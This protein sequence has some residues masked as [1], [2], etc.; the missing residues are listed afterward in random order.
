MFKFTF[1][2]ALHLHKY[3]G[4]MSSDHTL[5]NP[6]IFIFLYH[7][8]FCIIHYGYAIIYLTFALDSSKL[9]I[10]T[11]IHHMA[12]TPMDCCQLR[13]NTTYTSIFKSTLGS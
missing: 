1:E 4:F 9:N 8:T 6:R 10:H 12:I 3:Y 13:N 2:C 11:T 7:H 5:Y